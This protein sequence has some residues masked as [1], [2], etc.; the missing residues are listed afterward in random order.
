MDIGLLYAGFKKILSVLLL[1]SVLSQT[2]FTLVRSDF[3][4][5]SFL[6]ARHVLEIMFL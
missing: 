3:M 2:L 6:T 5:F 4:S 1:M